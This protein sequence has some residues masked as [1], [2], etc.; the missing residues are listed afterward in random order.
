MIYSK[1]LRKSELQLR[2]KINRS[3]YPHFGIRLKVAML[4]AK[5]NSGDLAIACGFKTAQGV[6]DWRYG[7]R[8]PTMAQVE[9]ITAE[10]GVS[11]EWLIR[12]KPIIIMD[13]L[14]WQLRSKT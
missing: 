3:L 4:I 6:H 1:P 2:R 11:R 14:D 5:K 7:L 12:N 13:E 8:Y 10:L 9:I